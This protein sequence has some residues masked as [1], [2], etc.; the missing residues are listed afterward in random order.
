MNLLLQHLFFRLHKYSFVGIQVEW[1]KFPKVQK[2]FT[3]KF[4]VNKPIA[5]IFYGYFCS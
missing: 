3:F 4:V 5:N 2:T 1:L